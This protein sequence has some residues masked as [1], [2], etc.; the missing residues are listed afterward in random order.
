MLDFEHAIERL[1]RWILGL[2]V[3]GTVVTLVRFG[4]GPAAAFLVGALAAW[5]NY[6]IIEK[7]SR[8]IED[9]ARNEPTPP[10]RG[11]GVFV[12]IQFAGLALGAIVILKFSGFS[13]AAAFCG[14]MVCPAAVIAEIV[15]ELF[16]YGHS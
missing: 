12:F 7:A 14:F 13:L 9:L 1:P 2:A 5:F 4:V 3:A 6:R 16:R 8:R 15:Y 11:A 10:G